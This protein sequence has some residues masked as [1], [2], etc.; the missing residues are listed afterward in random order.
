MTEHGS[1][2]P[3]DGS[4]EFRLVD[5]H[6]FGHRFENI[7]SP[8]AEEL[9]TLEREGAI[10][11]HFADTAKGTDENGSSEFRYYR[12][13]FKPA[14]IFGYVEATLA[15]LE[16]D[17][18]AA[19][20]ADFNTAVAAIRN[21]EIAQRVIDYDGE[22]VA[23]DGTVE[24]LRGCPASF[25][26]DGMESLLCGGR[27]DR[28]EELPV[29]G[30]ARDRIAQLMQILN[31]F[32]VVERVMRDRKQGRPAFVVENEYDVQDLL[33]AIIRAVFDD[34]KREEWT[35]QRAGSAKR[36]D[37]LI[38]SIETAIETKYVRDEN[39]AKK[40]ADELMVDIECYHA[41]PECRHLIAL[42]ID[43]HRHIPDPA[44]FGDD[45][46]GLRQKDGHTF[47][48]SVLVR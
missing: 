44:Q 35:P 26:P 28:Y 18:A 41:R 47:E 2:S 9:I 1:N 31:N 10:Y 22:W 20:G 38:A 11:S 27:R 37:M 30:E 4:D 46:S 6:A 42:V 24:D 29:A 14:E 16:Y 21:P 13:P 5:I 17:V 36:I 8:L 3:E 39:H 12:I 45:L 25:F 34:A 43:P 19:S 33:Y 23:P 32:P 40:V 15:N 48:V 7:P